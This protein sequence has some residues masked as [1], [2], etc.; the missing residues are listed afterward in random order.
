MH[1]CTVWAGGVAQMDTFGLLFFFFFSLFL[2]CA[3]EETVE[4]KD[5]E[6]CRPERETLGTQ[7][8][9]FVSWCRM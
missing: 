7:K 9:S 4:M 2:F 6:A 3:I 8:L 5:L 1:A